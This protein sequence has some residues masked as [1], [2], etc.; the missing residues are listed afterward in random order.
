MSTVAS[1]THKYME[2]FLPKGSLRDCLR[3]G[4]TRRSKKPCCLDCL[5]QHPRLSLFEKLFGQGG[6]RQPH[7]EVRVPNDVRWHDM[8]YM[9]L[10]FKGVSKRKQLKGLLSYL[11]RNIEK[12]SNELG[13]ERDN[14]R[15]LEIIT[16]APHVGRFLGFHALSLFS[17]ISTCGCGFKADLLLGYFSSFFECAGLCDLSNYPFQQENFV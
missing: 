1:R 14:A 16:S 9:C 15:M 11:Q 2:S 7:C 4:E 17:Q 3:K 8:P 6:Y 10:T 5:W 12:L 13:V